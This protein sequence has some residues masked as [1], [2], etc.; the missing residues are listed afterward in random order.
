M[1]TQAL[2]DMASR[3]DEQLAR[4]GVGPSP[5]AD[6][7][8]L[9]GELEVEA[10]PIEQ[11]RAARRLRRRQPENWRLLLDML[12][13]PDGGPLT[14]WPEGEADP[15]TLMVCLAEVRVHEARTA[16]DEPDDDQDAD[17]EDSQPPA[18]V[19]VS[20]PDRAWMDRAACRSMSIDLF[21]P[22]DADTGG[23]TA[24]KRVCGTCIARTD[25]LDYAVDTLQKDG[26][27]GGTTLQERKNLRRRRS[28]IAAVVE[29][30]P[31]AQPVVTVLE[32]H[33]G[34]C[35]VIQPAS[36]FGKDK[37]RSDGLNYWCRECTNKAARERRL[38]AR[39]V[40]A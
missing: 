12:G 7:R 28:R 16:P 30:I 35:G 39:Q 21:F 24:A 5:L 10:D 27:W 9:V 18:P 15:E 6:P 32:K 22:A 26:V 19:A 34:C 20:R 2:I 11:A 17:L 31:A 25:C 1:A 40:V 33:C 29:D 8:H 13:L 36:A 38:E 37:L 23:V 14:P 3:T 4:R